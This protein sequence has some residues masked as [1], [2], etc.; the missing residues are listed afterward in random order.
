MH[1]LLLSRG[2]LPQAATFY[3]I[4]RAERSRGILDLYRARVGSDHAGFV[5]TSYGESRSLLLHSSTESLADAPHFSGI[6]E[7]RSQVPVSGAS[8]S[9]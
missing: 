9:T 7:R 1:V 2:G 8:T 6:A 3:E 5:W 4:V